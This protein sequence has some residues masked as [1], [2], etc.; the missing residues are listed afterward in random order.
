MAKVS[1]TLS[2]QN[3]CTET[4]ASTKQLNPQNRTHQIF[5]LFLVLLLLGVLGRNGAATTSI[6]I[7]RHVY[8]NKAYPKRERVYAIVCLVKR[9]SCSLKQICSDL[10]NTKAAGLVFIRGGQDVFFIF[11]FRNSFNSL[12]F[13]PFCIISPNSKDLNLLYRIL[14]K[15]QSHYSVRI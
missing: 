10:G 8:Y 15:L 7:R 1:I 5:F 3:Y 6:W 9:S 2:I 4:L 11:F 13:H 14:K 12:N